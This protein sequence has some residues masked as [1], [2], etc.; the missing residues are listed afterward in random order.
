MIEELLFKVGIPT[1]KTN[2][3]TALTATK[4]VNLGQQAPTN[5]GWIYGISLNVSGT[6]AT[7]DFQGNT[8]ITLLEAANLWLN[9]KI[10]SNVFIED[11]RLSNFVYQEPNVT[12]TQDRNYMPVSI[13]LDLDWKQST[14]DNPTS[15]TG[16]TVNFDFYYIDKP[17]YAALLKSGVLW[18]T[19]NKPM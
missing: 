12:R 17:S 2:L 18:E 4:S 14:I 5:I 3:I 16:K 11:V 9:L 8:L 13:P 7:T 15:I 1:Y 10:G 6:S 19:G